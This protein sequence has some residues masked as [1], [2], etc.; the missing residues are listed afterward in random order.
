MHFL[1]MHRF[2]VITVLCNN[3]MVLRYSGTLKTLFD[4][5]DIIL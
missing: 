4:L 3:T 2:F 5:C 1:H